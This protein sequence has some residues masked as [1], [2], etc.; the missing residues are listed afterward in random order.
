MGESPVR[1]KTVVNVWKI[2]KIV[3]GC[4]DLMRLVRLDEDKGL[5]NSVNWIENLVFCFNNF[6]SI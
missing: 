4:S 2:N 5:Q 1:I 3:A 6:S